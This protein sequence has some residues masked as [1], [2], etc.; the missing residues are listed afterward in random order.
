MAES[1][2]ILS[3]LTTHLH[4]MVLGSAEMSRSG[5]VI[6]T[7]E[8]ARLAD[9]AAVIDKA[10]DARFVISVGTDCREHAQGFRVDHVFSQDKRKTWVVL[11]SY[12]SEDRP[13][14]ASIT[15]AVPAANW[16]EREFYDMLGIRAEGHPDPRR[17]IMAD[18]WPPDVFPLR[19]DFP[20]NK[21]PDPVAGHEQKLHDP[22]E[23][24]VTVP[25]GPFFPVLEEPAYFKVFTDGEAVVGM[26]Y[27]GFFSH[28]GIEKMADSKLTYNEIP[29]IAERICGI[30]GFVHSCSYVQAVENA[31]GID[32]PLRAKY[33]RSIVLELERLHSH[34]LWLGIAGHI[35]GF[36]TVLMQSWRMREPVMWMCE[37]I[38]GN[39]KTYGMNQV[40][41]VRRDITK[42]AA[43]ELLRVLDTLEK[44]WKALYSAVLDDTPLLMRLSNVGVLSRK[45][46]RSLGT[47][48]P[49]VRASDTPIDTRVDHP[50]AA[51]DQIE[52]KVV[53]KD[54]CD[55]AGR[56]L[57]R[58]E[59]TLESIKQVR[60]LIKS[61][62]AGKI[63]L[64]I[65]DPIPP[66][67]EGISAVE[68]PRG[69]V[70][71]YVQ[72]GE[73]ARPYRW[74][75]RAPTYANLQAMPTSLRGMSL[76]D[77]PITLGSMDPCFSCTERVQVVDVKSG[78]VTFLSKDDL[79]NMSRR[80]F[81]RQR[82]GR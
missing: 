59:E 21:R 25:I 55:V 17:L 60:A 49:T 28:R 75:V 42:D 71:H 12:A 50:Y 29:F 82:G 72:T 61:L 74:R 81:G 48:G 67:K 16:S 38:T 65:T 27:R 3:E 68:A 20:Y 26:D 18:D 34:P 62:P 76:A 11:R 24:C 30:C 78:A 53:T 56:T 69:E 41:G 47:V 8:P 1:P 23:N 73:D 10:L 40:G 5:A 7:V 70:I 43:T 44:E 79:E 9:A 64:P 33:I 46:C 39:R 31:A 14:V 37:K 52:V 51:Y 22:P 32:P 54:T 15:P 80:K 58:L 66:G 35:L 13:L 57:V 6:V 2:A 36:D 63:S 77:V 45:D 19:R 4:G